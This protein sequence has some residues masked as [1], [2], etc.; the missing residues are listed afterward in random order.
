[1]IISNRQRQHYLHREL[2]SDSAKQHY[3]YLLHRQAV[4]TRKLKMHARNPIHM[5]ERMSTEKHYISCSFSTRLNGYAF[6]GYTK[7]TRLQQ[8]IRSQICLSPAWH[9]QHVTS[10]KRHARDVRK[11]HQLSDPPSKTHVTGALR[12]HLKG[13][14]TSDRHDT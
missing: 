1:M 10:T 2:W 12:L 11:K 6:L 4:S 8:A 5:Y 14:K 7:T 13:T 3:P 9:A